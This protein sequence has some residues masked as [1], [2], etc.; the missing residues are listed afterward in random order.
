M[1][2]DSMESL[3]RDYPFLLKLMSKTTHCK[4]CDKCFSLV[5]TWKVR[6]EH[7]VISKAINVAPL[8]IVRHYLYSRSNNKHN[9]I[10]LSLNTS[11]MPLF[12][13]ITL[14]EFANIFFAAFLSIILLELV[15]WFS[16]SYMINN[17]L[18][19]LKTLKSIW[20]NND[21]YL[22]TCDYPWPWPVHK[23]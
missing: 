17:Q 1:F 21:W 14:W 5:S 2:L 4:C 23:C 22:A 19:I 11:I 18:D 15:P 6:F 8:L 9:S 3:F 12:F 20:F 13:K 16:S 10:L 7:R